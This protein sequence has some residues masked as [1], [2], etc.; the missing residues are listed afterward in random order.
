MNASDIISIIDIVASA[1]LGIW[2][3]T[4]ITK[5]QTKERFLKG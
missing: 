4:A 3:A 5:S 2:I 1:G